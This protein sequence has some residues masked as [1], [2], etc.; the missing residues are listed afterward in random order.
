VQG[1][2]QWKNF[3]SLWRHRLNHFKYGHGLHPL[4]LLDAAILIKWILHIYFL[5]VHMT[6][7]HRVPWG[8][9]VYDV[10]TSTM[11]WAPTFWTSIIPSQV[12]GLDK[13]SSLFA[14]TQRLKGDRVVA[15]DQPINIWL[16]YHIWTVSATLISSLL[17]HQEDDDLAIVH[18]VS[19]VKKIHYFSFH[20][21]N[22]RVE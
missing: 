12:V 6:P 14:S 10:K 20:T 19:I 4:T 3:S 17:S 15:S 11:F 5:G 18:L 22:P 13:A 2:D 9:W 16:Q 21:V 7:K 1:E 8:C